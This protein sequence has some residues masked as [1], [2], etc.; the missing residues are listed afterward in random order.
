MRYLNAQQQIVSHAL[1]TDGFCMSWRP[2]SDPSTRAG[3]SAF[4][5]LVCTAV[6]VALFAAGLMLYE[7]FWESNDDVGMSM[8]AHGYGIA[9]S[10]S[11]LLLFQNV[12]VGYLL[13]VLP[14]I[15]GVLPYSWLQLALMLISGA[16]LLYFVVRSGGAFGLAVIA[17][18]LV[19]ARFVAAPQFT[20]TAGL[21]TAAGVLACFSHIRSPSLPALVAG[22]VLVIAGYLVRPEEC[23]F[24][25]LVALPLVPW[26][27]ISVGRAELVTAGLVLSFLAFA[28]LF[29]R[30][31]YAGQEWVAFNAME[32]L[33]GE[34]TDFSYAEQ[35]LK[36]PEQMRAHGFSQNDI[37]LIS[38]WFYV[39]TAVAD[40]VRLQALFSDLPFETRFIENLYG[41]W[42]AIASLAD[43][44]IAP[45]LIAAAVLS[46]LSRCWLK[47][48]ASWVVFLA[49]ISG[50]GLAGRP[51]VLHAYYPVPVLLMFAALECRLRNEVRKPML[52]VV[53]WAVLLATLVMMLNV[54]I[55]ENRKFIERSRDAREDVARLDWSKTHVVWGAVF[56]TEL[57]LP[58]LERQ[59]E[60]FDFPQYGLGWESLTPFSIHS[61]EATPWRDL[62]DRIER[63]RD[64]PVIAS[65]SNL[66]LL[67]TYCRE[68]HHKELTVRET[69]LNTFTLFNVTCKKP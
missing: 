53:P 56:P 63:D 35:I 52:R 9:K 28:T 8:I 69:P 2:L 21:A 32:P 41:G 50:Y 13:Q 65:K 34:L 38:N 64:I 27:K 7:P 68:H 51:G 17:L 10:P 6:T 14:R 19:F 58:V 43:P 12:L 36:H 59:T 48:I 62:A 15:D 39:D 33:R 25:V 37:Q 67:A 31:Q 49:V 46:F 16:G 11:P 42:N 5:L 30:Q 4:W 54:N 40:P 23:I 66:E 61:F 3:A 55:V 60:R 18:A 1:C 47:A 29:D 26:H 45:L 20:I 22:A 57:A 44:T 24:L